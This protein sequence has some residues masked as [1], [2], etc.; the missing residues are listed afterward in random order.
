MN[1]ICD[2]DQRGVIYRDYS[3][4]VIKLRNVGER[5]GIPSLFSGGHIY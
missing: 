5:I 3:K 2:V 1:G 4:Q